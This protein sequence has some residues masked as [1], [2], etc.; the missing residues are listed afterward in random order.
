MK[1]PSRQRGVHVP[2]M[3]IAV[4]LQ[5][6]SK[7]VKEMDGHKL[8]KS[9][10]VRAFLVDDLDRLEHVSD[11]YHIPPA[12]PFDTEVCT[13][14]NANLCC[15]LCI[16]LVKCHILTFTLTVCIIIQ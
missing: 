6:A 2:L 13:L 10:L 12:V 5:E 7:A 1:C 3:L 14:S 9:H 11:D 8:D 16:A 15:L 4:W